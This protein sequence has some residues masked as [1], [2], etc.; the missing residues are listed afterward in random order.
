MSRIIIAS[1]PF[2][3]A[4]TV[5]D[6]LKEIANWYDAHQIRPEE[7]SLS[8][9]WYRGMGTVRAD[10]LQPGVYREQFSQKAKSRREQ[11]IEEKRLNL[12]REMLN[13]FRTMGADYLKRYDLTEQYFIAQ[14]FGMPTRLLD[15]TTNPLA[16]LFF[17]VECQKDHGEDGEVFV[18]EATGIFSGVKRKD[19]TVPTHIASM[20]HP[21]VRATVEEIFWWKKIEDKERLILAVRPDNQPG[22]I[23]QQSSC[24]TLHM[25]KS[26]DCTNPTLERIT[27]PAGA[28]RKMLT[29]LA[30]LNINEFT[31]YNDLDHLS[32][33]I[34]RAWGVA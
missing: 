21:Y 30:R 6:Y 25:H 10:A 17:A 8:G 12:E 32:Q 2:A 23:G 24:F 34:R 29:D 28:K 16:G 1:K 14:H 4:P 27:I 9:I 7:K 20:H 18:M 13:E 26:Q 33:H 19:K 3:P 15:W 5:S 22:R 31:I 11:G